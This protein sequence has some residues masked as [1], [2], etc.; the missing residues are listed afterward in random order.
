MVGEVL[1]PILLEA[2]AGV[3]GVNRLPFRP[4]SLALAGLRQAE[5]LRLEVERQQLMLQATRLQ[6]KEVGVEDACPARRWQ[7]WT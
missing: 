3:P 4:P 1:V 6:D 5:K 7:P 2:G